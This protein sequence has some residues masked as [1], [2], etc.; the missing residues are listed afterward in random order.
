MM[1]R[2]S[3]GDLSCVY[4]HRS[5]PC[6][7]KLVKKIREVRFLRKSQPG[8]RQKRTKARCAELLEYG[9]FTRV[10]GDPMQMLRILFC[11]SDDDAS[12]SSSRRLHPGKTDVSSS[13]IAERGLKASD[14][15]RWKKL[16]PDIYF[17]E[18][19]HSPDPDGHIIN[20][21]S[22]IVITTDGVAVLDG[23]GD[24]AQTQAPVE[25]IRKLT[26]QPIKYVIVGSEHGDHTGA[27]RR[28]RQRFRTCSPSP[29]QLR[30]RL[31]RTNRIRQPKPFWTNAC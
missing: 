17:Y 5:H 3:W 20:T 31:W 30:K 18:G 12:S 24:V 10:E 28:S 27:I 14:F 25:T 1:P 15:P 9:R 7:K 21:G 26:P 11:R 6:R 23:Q 2:L 29:L 22:L 8:N 16:K 4:S 19:L 13:D